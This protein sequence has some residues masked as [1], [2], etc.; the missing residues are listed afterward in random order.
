MSDRIAAAASGQVQSGPG[1][2]VADLKSSG[3]LRIGVGLVP[4]FA[5]R[6]A[7]TGEV[8][9]IA[10]ELGRALAERLGV[11]P[12]PVTYPSPANLPAALE[13]GAWDIAFLAVDPARE[14]AMDFSIPYAQ[15]DSTFLVAPNSAHRSFN[16][17]DGPGVRISATRNSVEDLTL[18]RLIKAAEIVRLDSALAGLEALKSGK[19]DAVAVPRPA[20]IAFAE[21]I[22]GAHVL[23]DRYAVA[24][25]AIAVPKGR[26]DH[27]NDINDFL[28]S[29][30]KSGLVR[31]AMER[32]GLRGAEVAP[33]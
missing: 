11:E 6:N 32:V 18:T 4:T 26:S 30:K 17:L 16:D 28:S 7:S 5:T 29:A 8:R 9:G 22:T 3:K 14:A 33:D 10:I 1:S 15:V 21:Q 2:T 12:V 13:V 25:H 19:V 31:Q 24:L 23:D 20:A 27:L